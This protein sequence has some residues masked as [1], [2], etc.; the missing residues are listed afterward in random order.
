MWR[1]GDDR[2]RRRDR[3]VV[4]VSN[5]GTVPNVFVR[6]NCTNAGRIVATM[7]SRCSILIGRCVATMPVAHIRTT[8][9]VKN[10]VVRACQKLL[11]WM[12]EAGVAPRRVQRHRMVRSV[13]G[14]SR[15]VGPSVA[16]PRPSIVAVM[17]VSISRRNAAR[18]LTVSVRS[19]AIAARRFARV[20]PARSASQMMQPARTIADAALVCAMREPARV[21]AE[22]NSSAVSTALVVPASAMADSA[23]NASNTRVFA[24]ATANAVQTFA[25]VACARHAGRVGTAALAMAI[26]AP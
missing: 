1:R 23:R 22:I 25:K 11:A 8:V 10:S 18:L 3:S 9:L 20:E 16:I 2:R 13:V 15:C 5:T 17:C 24:L 7:V 21:V 19:T 4:R 6:M 12:S 26:A 14:W